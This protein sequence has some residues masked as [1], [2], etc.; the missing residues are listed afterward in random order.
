M[1]I[2]QYLHRMSTVIDPCHSSTSWIVIHT[3]LF[4]TFLYVD[5]F[6]G[7]PFPDLTWYQI[8]KKNNPVPIKDD[9]KHTIHVLLSHGQTLSVAEVWY[10]LTII[11]VQS[12]DYGYYWC[13]GRNRMGS[14]HG[15][16][17]LYSKHLHN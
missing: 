4:L 1:C 5:I 6:A 17:Q 11:N 13:E 10:Q 3:F 7:Y 16:V 14:H 9:E 15:L 8:D 2:L 12:N